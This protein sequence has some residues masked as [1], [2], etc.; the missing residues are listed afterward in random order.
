MA[1]FPAELEDAYAAV[2]FRDVVL[3][4]LV[5]R[6]DFDGGPPWLQA[7]GSARYHPGADFDRA[8][9]AAFHAIMLGH[10]GT[11]DPESLIPDQLALPP[12][13]PPPAG[14]QACG[15]G[16][17]MQLARAAI[18]AQYRALQAAAT[19]DDL[20]SLASVR[21]KAEKLVKMT[22]EYIPAA[23]SAVA[24]SSRGWLAILSE[25]HGAMPGAP[26]PHKI[27]KW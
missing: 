10:T 4:G 8:R 5:R 15:A 2:W 1:T 27:G 20:S 24:H 26:L 25:T 22:D 16:Q 3:P 11:A 6:V 14:W 9:I 21:R 19:I 13:D 18:S 12:V 7:Y 17:T 23:H